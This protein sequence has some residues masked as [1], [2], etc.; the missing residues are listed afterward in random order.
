MGRDST[1]W[2]SISAVSTP[3]WVTTPDRQDRK[4]RQRAETGSWPVWLGETSA[5]VPQLKALLAPY[6]SGKDDM[7][8]GEPTGRRQK[9]NDPSLIA[10]IAAV[11]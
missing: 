9:N 11:G 8:A 5:D 2:T 7:L 10:P 3:T 1:S 6:P 4:P